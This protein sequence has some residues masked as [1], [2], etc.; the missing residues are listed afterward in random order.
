MQVASEAAGREA[1]F[2]VVRSFGLSKTTSFFKVQSL[3][4]ERELKFIVFL[5]EAPNYEQVYR[6]GTL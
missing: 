1:D 3:N 5:S 6:I 2:K 4:F